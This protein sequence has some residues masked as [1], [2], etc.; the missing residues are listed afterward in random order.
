MST[1]SA[2]KSPRPKTP[3]AAAPSPTRITRLE[4]KEELA[5]LNKRLEVYILKNR[6]KD[7]NHGSVQREVDAVRERAEEE[8]QRM[9]DLHQQQ[10]ADLRKAR[11]DEKLAN[12]RLNT[13]HKANV[14]ELEAARVEIAQLRQT[15]DRLHDQNQELQNDLAK[16]NMENA[17]LQNQCDANKGQL[18]VAQTK[19]SG[20]EAE[21]ENLR[22]ALADAQERADVAEAK[23]DASTSNTDNNVAKLQA[24]IKR[25]RKDLDA[26]NHKGSH[27]EDELRAELSEQLTEIIAKRQQEWEEDKGDALAELKAIYD[28]KIQ[29]YRDHL[30]RAGHELEMAKAQR[31]QAVQEAEENKTLREEFEATR[32]TLKNR[33]VELEE[34]VKSERSRPSRE[35]AEKIEI[36]RR[37][38]AAFKRKDEEFD[39]LMDVKIAL[40]MEIKAYRQLLEKEEQRLGYKSPGAGSKR[41]RTGGSSFTESHTDD[42]T[43]RFSGIDVHGR[44]ITI[45]NESTEDTALEGWTLRSS[46]RGTQLEL[47]ADLVLSAGQSLTIWTGADA[48]EKHNPPS[49]IGWETVGNAW[50]DVHGDVA[51]LL[52]P[53][54][55]L[56]GSVDIVPE[57]YSLPEDA[58]ATGPDGQK[59]I[60]M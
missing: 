34:A 14:Q 46:A 40:A 45:R 49:E 52:D 50:D 25:L 59:C 39:Q 10:L 19:L 20:A 32:T 11:D 48:K 15:N 28:E 42:A 44:Y 7:A 58:T 16:K 54:G 8:L 12:A 41:R 56:V 36:I 43:L 60:L 18:A 38:K 23:L 55:N 53:E 3:R 21:L 17:Q 13:E 51:E 29:A 24:E 33:I 47:P 2:K 1:A 27:V 31:E 22:N 9:E 6:E 30:E 4:D 37:L 35:L 57:N 26:S 5:E